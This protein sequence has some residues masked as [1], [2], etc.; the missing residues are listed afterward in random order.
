M[1]LAKSNIVLLIAAVV[2]AQLTEK[3]QLK[4][5]I[6]DGLPDGR[7]WGVSAAKS[8]SVSTPK[9]CGCCYESS[10]ARGKFSEAGRRGPTC[11]TRRR[12]CKHKGLQG[13]AATGA[14]AAG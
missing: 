11:A 14:F 1:N 4:V 8:R 5:G 9:G 7:T 13:F 10:T 6:W 3:W 12:P 2:L